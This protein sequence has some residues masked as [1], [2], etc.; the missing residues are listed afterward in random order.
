MT[1]VYYDTEFLDDGECIH[2]ISVGMVADDES[3]YYAVNIDAPWDDIKR[4]KFLC[5][6]VVPHLPLAPSGIRRLSHGITF[7]VDLTHE[8][9][10]PHWVIANEVRAYL[11]ARQEP[12]QLWAYYGAYDHVAL[13]QLWGPM[14]ELP[15]GVP[16]FTHELKQEIERHGI[17]KDDVSHEGEHH[18]LA[19][20]RWNHAMGDYLLLHDNV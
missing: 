16:K 2:L 14:S 15:Q 6:N 12:L 11:Q 9:V 18:A 3:Q 7:Q 4:H 13:V 5:N 19:D 20:A 1:R 8:S 17:D 10:K